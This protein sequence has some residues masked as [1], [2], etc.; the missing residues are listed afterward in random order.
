MNANLIRRLCVGETLHS[1]H[2]SVIEPVR[3]SICPETRV[4]NV[5][6]DIQ[7]FKT[8]QRYF[9]ILIVSQLL[10]LFHNKIFNVPR[11]VNGSF[12]FFNA[13]NFGD[14]ARISQIS[15]VLGKN[16]TI[17]SQV[18]KLLVLSGCDASIQFFPSS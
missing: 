7:K 15:F 3:G 13:D 14:R 10:G 16:L 8:L 5:V 4:L 9:S 11:F 12:G 17:I 1:K 18:F 6:K 2:I